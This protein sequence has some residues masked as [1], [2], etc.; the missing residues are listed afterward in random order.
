MKTKIISQKHFILLLIISLLS[1][2]AYAQSY[3]WK[4]EKGSDTINPPG[5]YGTPGIAAISNNPCGREAGARWKDASGNF[6]LFGGVHYNSAH[7]T[8]YLSDL[9]KYNPS[10]NQWTFVKGDSIAGQAG[11]YGTIG[12]PSITNKPGA[13]IRS[14]SWTDLNG[15]FW[16]FGGNGYGSIGQSGVL[17][18]L[19]KYDPTNNQWTWIN[20]SSN[21]NQAGTYGTLG[22]SSAGNIPGARSA[23]GSWTDASGNLWMFG[24]YGFDHTS[25]FGALSDLW[26]FNIS[27]NQWTWV[28]GNNLSDQNGIYGTI[29]IQSSLNKPGGRFGP[30]TWADASGNLWLSSGSGFAATNSTNQNLNDL[31]KY[32][33]STNQWT[34]IKGSNGINQSGVYGTQGVA[35][36]SNQPGSRSLGTGWSD[37]AGNLWL[38]GGMGFGDSSTQIENYLNDLWQY[39]ITT[40]EWTWLKGGTVPKQT[41]IYGTQGI[42]SVLNT[43]GSHMNGAGWM[44]N[45]GS[46]WL[47]GGLGYDTNL[48]S[49]YGYLN[50]LWKFG[51]CTT[52]TI[53]ATDN[54]SNSC[55]GNSVTLSAHGA[56]SY[57]WSTTQNTGTITV[58]PVSNTTYTV[59]SLDAN[60]CGNY[61]TITRTVL[62]LPVIHAL[63]SNTMACL[64][65]MVTLTASGALTYSWSNNHTGQSINVL[66]TNTLYTITGT[67]AN[68]CVDTSSISQVALLCSG[69]H[70]YA[71]EHKSFSV[72]PNPSAGMFTLVST[73]L[74]EYTTVTIMNSL[75]QV[76]VKLEDIKSGE[77]II[78]SLE[79]GIYYITAKDQT[80]KTFSSKLIIE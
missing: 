66:A 12:T 79:K 22:A 30:I 54:S 40:N 19:W 57:S 56:N 76:K 29:S 47:F 35:S 32:N 55:A 53:S 24:G 17:N 72:S 63:S 31:W 34:W 67:D 61:A 74:N 1:Q 11:N 33:I 51:S 38:F 9:W 8:E 69:I 80:H 25:S 50:D 68:G 75:G 2:G 77:I 45:T 13:R 15:N 21:A 73:D 7:N 71:Y 5:F 44:D 18:D 36:A 78:T 26:M 16:M 49:G 6:W 23:A 70:P 58:S 20:G 46:L 48:T 14:V 52:Q 41:G 60:G 65:D 59:Y 39:N 28:N 62:P 4:W 43:P 27:T 42:P 3:T 10:I 37:A 64:G